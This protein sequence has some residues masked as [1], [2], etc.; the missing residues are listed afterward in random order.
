MTVNTWGDELIHVFHRRTGAELEKSLWKKLEGWTGVHPSMYP[1][2]DSVAGRA[3]EIVESLDGGGRTV[4]VEGAGEFLGDGGG[5]G[6][7]DGGA[8]HQV[9]ELAVAEDGDGG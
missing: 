4:G 6:G 3:T 2:E 8:L 7:L 5:G 9:D 1:V